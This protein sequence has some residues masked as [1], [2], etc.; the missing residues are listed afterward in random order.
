M[1]FLHNRSSDCEYSLI[2]GIISHTDDIIF[3]KLYD[4]SGIA[5]SL[6]DPGSGK[7]GG[8]QPGNPR[9]DELSGRLAP[10]DS[11]WLLETFYHLIVCW[12]F[13]TDDRNDCGT[14]DPSSSCDD[15]ISTPAD[16][17]RS[18]KKD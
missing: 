8:I 15:D 10:A 12:Q 17:A 1:S 18:T 7:E 9:I 14:W 5:A 3:I 11:K 4:K 13:R 2:S 6:F 16:F